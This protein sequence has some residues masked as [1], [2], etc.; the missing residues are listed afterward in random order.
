[1]TKAELL[2]VPKRKW[3]EELMD[4]QEIYIIPSKRKHESGYRCMD[5]VAVV[6][7]KNNEKLIG[8]GRCCDALHFM[9]AGDFTIDVSPQ[10][11][12]IRIF[13]RGNK[14]IKISK[15]CSDIFVESI[16]T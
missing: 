12:V 6:G 1:M 4:V 16:K 7:E 13:R 3:D 5:F 11:N 9:N 15:D 8:F 14:T 2:A 10:N